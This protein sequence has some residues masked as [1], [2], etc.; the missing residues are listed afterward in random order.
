MYYP[1]KICDKKTG[2]K[3]FRSRSGYLELLTGYY[4][5]GYTSSTCYTTPPTL[6][7]GS[8]G[9]VRVKDYGDLYTDR[10]MLGHDSAT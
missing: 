4:W 1:N 6:I 7:G 2:R 9:Y 3:C 10:D 8:S 5:S